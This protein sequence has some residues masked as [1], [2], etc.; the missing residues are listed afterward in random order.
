MTK[1]SFNY[2]EEKVKLLERSIKSNK[3]FVRTY[4]NF[5]YG[6]YLITIMNLAIGV[7]DIEYLDFPFGFVLSM[8]LALFTM[9]CAGSNRAMAKYTNKQIEWDEL[10]LNFYKNGTKRSKAMEQQLEI[11]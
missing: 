1:S 7:V 8:V 11:P 2:V 3:R 9:H 5:E 6:F 10:E 4:K